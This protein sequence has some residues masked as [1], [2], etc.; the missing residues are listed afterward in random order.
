MSNDEIPENE[1][2][3]DEMNRVVLTNVRKII[4]LI[5][6]FR[7]HVRVELETLLK[8][9]ELV[10]LAMQCFDEET[11]DELKNYPWTNEQKTPKQQ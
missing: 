3:N 11:Y 2:L 8:D 5:K 9:E 7:V 1:T 10:K 4:D 6:G